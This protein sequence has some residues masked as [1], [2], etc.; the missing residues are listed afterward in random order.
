MATDKCNC[1]PSHTPSDI[2]GVGTRGNATSTSQKCSR[3][4]PSSAKSHVQMWSS[5]TTSGKCNKPVSSW[6]RPMVSSFA[7]K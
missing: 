1:M 7:R 3:F 5:S 6:C 2:F 4:L